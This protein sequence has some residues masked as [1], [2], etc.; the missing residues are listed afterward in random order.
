MAEKLLVKICY[1]AGYIS[2][3]GCLC[4]CHPGK[5]TVIKLQWLVNKVDENVPTTS[6]AL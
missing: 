5:L 4:D 2:F 3:G 6:D 1:T